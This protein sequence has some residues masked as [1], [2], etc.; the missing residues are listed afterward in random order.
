MLKI[1]CLIIVL[2]E[3]FPERVLQGKNSIYKSFYKF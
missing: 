3:S 1:M 2:F